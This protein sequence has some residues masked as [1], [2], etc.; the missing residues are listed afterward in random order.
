MWTKDGSSGFVQKS[1]TWHLV[2]PTDKESSGP[3]VEW[4]T[5]Q[6]ITWDEMYGIRTPTPVDEDV[7]PPKLAIVELPARVYSMLSVITAVLVAMLLLQV[8]GH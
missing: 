2:P 4:G 3:S 6:S 1:M 8:L 7:T 5:I